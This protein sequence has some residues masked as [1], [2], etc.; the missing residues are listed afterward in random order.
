MTERFLYT[1][2]TVLEYDYGVYIR[3]SKPVPPMLKVVSSD[4]LKAD[5]KLILLYDDGTD[6][7]FG[8]RDGLSIE[9]ERGRPILNFTG[10]RAISRATVPFFSGIQVRLDQ[11]TAEALECHQKLDADPKCGPT[12]TRSAI[13]F[14]VGQ[15]QKGCDWDDA[16]LQI[17]SSKGQPSLVMFNENGKTVPIPERIAFKPEPVLVERKPVPAVVAEF[18]Q[19]APNSVPPIPRDVRYPPPVREDNTNTL[20]SRKPDLCNDGFFHHMFNPFAYG[21]QMLGALF[22]PRKHKGPRP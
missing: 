17:K 12:L 2:L 20:P 7:F 5:R 16:V 19:R 6:I 14:A 1:R 22:S 18:Q 8:V 10:Y 9:D 13:Q 4:F 3:P 11:I 15:P 21:K